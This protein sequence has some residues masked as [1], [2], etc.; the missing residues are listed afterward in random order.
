[1][2]FLLPAAFSDTALRVDPRL[3]QPEIMNRS[4]ASSVKHSREKETR[5]VLKNGA[6]S[7]VS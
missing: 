6:S 3:V 5:P 7:S 2:P 1:M 4:T